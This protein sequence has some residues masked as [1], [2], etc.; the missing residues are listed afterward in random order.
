MHRGQLGFEAYLLCPSEGGGTHI[1]QL[2]RE[3]RFA[4]LTP[5]PN[6]TPIMYSRGGFPDVACYVAARFGCCDFVVGLHHCSSVELEAPSK[7]ESTWPLL[8]T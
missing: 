8:S 7:I 1:T 2:L 5:K 3:D 4:A 6:Q